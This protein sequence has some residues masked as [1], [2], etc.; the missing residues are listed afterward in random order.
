MRF[1][2]L[3]ES[4]ERQRYISGITLNVGHWLSLSSVRKCLVS[5]Y[6]FNLRVRE[7]C[8]MVGAPSRFRSMTFYDVLQ[9]L[10]KRHLLVVVVSICQT[11]ESMPSVE[12]LN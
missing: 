2:G 10:H 1:P 12:K 4:E 5:A 7:R 11:S 9:T 3:Q 6:L 8:D